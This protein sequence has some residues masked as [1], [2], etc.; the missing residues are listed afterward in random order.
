MINELVG[1]VTKGFVTFVTV[2]PKNVPAFIS[3][4]K[5]NLIDFSDIIEHEGC[6]DEALDA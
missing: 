5:S 3:D 1:D 2:I 4:A 6:K